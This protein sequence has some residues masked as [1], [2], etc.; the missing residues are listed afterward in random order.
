[1]PG[2][3]CSHHLIGQNDCGTLTQ[4]VQSTFSDVDE[5]VELPSVCIERRLLSRVP[6][7]APSPGVSLG[8]ARVGR[9]PGLATS[10]GPSLVFFGCQFALALFVN[11]H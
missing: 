10:S 8:L 9:I 5:D 6:Q 3:C 1:M 11:P 7:H 4:V 2:L